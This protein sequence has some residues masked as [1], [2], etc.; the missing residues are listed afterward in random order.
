MEY[1]VG[2]ELLLNIIPKHKDFPALNGRGDWQQ[3]Y[4]ALRKVSEQNFW[5]GI[6][7]EMNWPA[8]VY[9]LGVET[10]TVFAAK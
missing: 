2:S 9:E 4:K 10:L 7:L 6:Y 5:P 1:L 8:R 3:I